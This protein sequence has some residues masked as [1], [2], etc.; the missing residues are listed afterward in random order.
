MCVRSGR[1]RPGFLVSSG[2]QLQ[3]EHF[4]TYQEAYIT[5][6]PEPRE[7]DVWLHH[8]GVTIGEVGDKDFYPTLG[9]NTPSD[10]FQGLCRASGGWV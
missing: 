9:R 4:S 1:N 2:S 3:P 8:M 7:S 5:K 6:K 10:T